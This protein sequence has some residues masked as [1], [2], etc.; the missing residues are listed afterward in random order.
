MSY[1][2]NFCHF[3]K[4]ATIMGSIYRDVS[5]EGCLGEAAPGDEVF[6]WLSL[7]LQFV[8]WEVPIRIADGDAGY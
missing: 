4:P 1:Q 6:N 5:Y 7:G 3:V 2:N 8:G